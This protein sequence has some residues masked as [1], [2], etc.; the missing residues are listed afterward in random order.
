[1]FRLHFHRGRLGGLATFVL[2]VAAV[3]PVGPVAAATSVPLH[4]AHV[5]TMAD[6]GANGILWHFVLNQLDS[7]TAS[8]SVT[9]TFASAG[10][11]SDAGEPVG[12]GKVQHFWIATPSADTLEAASA[13][14]AD[15]SGSPKL[16]LSHWECGG[17]TPNT[18]PSN[19]PSNPPGTPP[20]GENGGSS[21]AVRDNT[22]ANPREDTKGSSS[23]PVVAALPNTA[24]SGATASTFLLVGVALLGGATLATA[25]LT[26][27]PRRR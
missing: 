3:A 5:G 1:M 24:M 15:Q 6:C 9:A 17:A 27:R 22:G 18:P 14:V 13:S 10:D 12:N 20:S 23:G 19:P 26:V 4:Q 8:G 21:G 2:A 7:G 16:V 25:K 11:V